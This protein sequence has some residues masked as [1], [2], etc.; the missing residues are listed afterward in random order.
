M[1][2]K[3]R[4]TRTTEMTSYR[5]I[6]LDDLGQFVQQCKEEGWTGSAYVTIHTQP[7]DRP[8]DRTVNTL[9]VTESR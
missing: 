7:A 6:T 1:T 3:I 2:D 9:R 8:G 5:D 4:T